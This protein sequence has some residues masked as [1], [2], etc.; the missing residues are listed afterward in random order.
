MRNELLI[1]DVRAFETEVARLNKKAVKIGVPPV[2]INPLGKETARR[3]VVV[4]S[5]GETVKEDVVPVDVI[6]YEV[7]TPDVEDR[8]WQLCATITPVE[9]EKPFVEAN[10]KGFDLTPWENANVCRC[11]H[12]R[13]NRFRNISYVVK[14]RETSATM[15]LGRDCFEDYVGKDTLRAMEFA[16]FVQI[17]LDGD[18]EGFYPASSGRG[19]IQAVE[20]IRCVAVAE[21]IA[22]LSACGWRNNEKDDFGE[23]VA[24]G[25]H[26]QAARIIRNESA[27]ATYCDPK[28]IV[29]GLEVPRGSLR[30]QVDFVIAHTDT[31]ARCAEAICR[32]RDMEVPADDEFATM[33]KTVA[34][35][36][37]I[38]VK[39]ASIAAYICQFL[40][41]HDRKAAFEAKKATMTHVGTVGARMDFTGLKVVKVHSFDSVYGTTFINIFEDASGNELVWKTG[42][43]S[44][45]VGE[46]ISLKGTIKEHGERNGAKQTILTR[47]KV[48]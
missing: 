29:G 31:Y 10:L 42:S 34:E 47:C 19:G 30:T 11:D 37:Y 22:A 40:R 6:R 43:S 27:Y 46:V 24:E 4:S 9:G 23:I 48:L 32:L 36:Q 33:L 17:S 25:T 2:R 26:R 8:K 41:N 35:Y 16:S 14:N 39:K 28:K 44:F 7:I 45:N 12:C 5:E 21:A 3:V 1:S 20:T 13:V 15:Q 18:D 38:P